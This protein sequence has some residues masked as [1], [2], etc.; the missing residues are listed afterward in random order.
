MFA[1]RT[2][3]EFIVNEYNEKLLFAALS[4]P[5][6]LLL[7]V[8]IACVIFFTLE[9]MIHCMFCPNKVRYFFSIHHILKLVLCLTMTTSTILEFRKDLLLD[10]FSLGW[11]YFTCKSFNVFRLCLIFRLHL[12]YNGL[13]I[14]LLSVK[15]SLKELLLLMFCFAAAVIVYGCLMFSVEINTDMFPSTQVAMWWSLITMTTIGYGDYY[16][17]CALGYIVGMLC[18]ISGLIVLAMPIAA[19]AGTFS[20]F[21]LRNADYQKHKFEIERQEKLSVNVDCCTEENKQQGNDNENKTTL[22]GLD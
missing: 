19:I 13:H 1:N 22:E 20:N 12:I 2:L 16:P 11:F 9:T 21:N 14:I 6:P 3:Y 10:N 8:D 7:G 5:H 4:D 15:Q 17:T 18:A